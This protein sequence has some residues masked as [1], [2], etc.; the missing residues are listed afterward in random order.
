MFSIFMV[1]TS[2]YHKKS[3]IWWNNSTSVS[4]IP[5]CTDSG[6]FWGSFRPLYGPIVSTISPLFLKDSSF[7]KNLH[8][9]HAVYNFRAGG[10][11]FRDT[12]TLFASFKEDSSAVLRRSFFVL[13][14]KT[15]SETKGRINGP[16][17]IFLAGCI[18][19]WVWNPIKS[20]LL[21]DSWYF[22]SSEAHLF[23]SMLFPDGK[24]QSVH[25][26]ESTAY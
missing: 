22:Q 18:S 25:D 17:N 11:R 1:V 7:K 10:V 8:I 23:S 12:G 21:K 19:Y 3:G 5:W 9:L 26:S 20:I 13:S 4:Y 6:P 24:A 2:T 14:M 16:W 15:V